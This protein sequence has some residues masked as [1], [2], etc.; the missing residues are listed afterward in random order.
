MSQFPDNSD[1]Q[2]KFKGQWKRRIKRFFRPLNDYLGWTLSWLLD[3]VVG[4]LIKKT[5]EKTTVKIA[6]LRLA[7][8]I[9]VVVA[10]YPSII[11]RLH[12]YHKYQQDKLVEEV[13]VR[14]KGAVR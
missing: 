4:R 11:G 5:Q 2:I 12:A 3:S 10:F 7:I 9:I 6:L 8:A 1:I 13:V 14:M